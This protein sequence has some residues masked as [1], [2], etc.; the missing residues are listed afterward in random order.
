MQTKQKRL[1][2]KAMTET[3]MLN[4]KRDVAKENSDET[5]IN[6]MKLGYKRDN[7]SF[8]ISSMRP[9]KYEKTTEARKYCR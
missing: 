7:A 9:Y 3:T 4:K 5:R 8:T 6:Q 2:Y 1:L